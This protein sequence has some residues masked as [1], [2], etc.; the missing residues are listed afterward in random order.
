VSIRKGEAFGIDFLGLVK[1]NEAITMGNRK[2]DET[3][4]K[5][6]NIHTKRI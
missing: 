6:Q 3:P 1:N 4:P 2:K 5:D